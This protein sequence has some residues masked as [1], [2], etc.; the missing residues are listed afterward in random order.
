MFIVFVLTNVA[1]SAQTPANSLSGLQSSV[2]PDE[3]LRVTDLNGRTTQGLFA[4]LSAG[5]VRLKVAPRWPASNWTE[6]EFSETAIREIT[7]RRRDVWWNGVLIGSGAGAGLGVAAAL[8][9][10]AGNGPP[11]GAYIFSLSL[12]GAGIGA[13]I[14][15]LNKKWDPVF[16]LSRTGSN[17]AL[18]FLP[19]VSNTYNGVHLSLSF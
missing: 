11:P 17:R 9:D 15:S 2:L 6:Q 3:L 14:D 12:L 16:V 8:A 13:W 5:S 7:K 18:R 1:A 4:G 10:S 19:I